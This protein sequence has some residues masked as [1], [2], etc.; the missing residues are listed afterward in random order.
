[1]SDATKSPST[2]QPIKPARPNAADKYIT[3]QGPVYLSG[4]QAYIRVT[5]EQQ[6][7]DREAGLKTGGF[8]S[9]YRGS[10][11]GHFDQDVA[12]VRPAMDER[13]I[14]FNP[15]V[16][17]AMAA[18]SV[19]GSQQIDFF[20]AS[21]YDGVFGMWYGKGPGVDQA[22]DALHHANLWGT[23][24]H[25][26]VVMA[27][28]DDPMSRSSSIQQQSEYVLSGL[29]I[30]TMACS[31]VQ[32]I[33]DYGLIAY[34]ISRYAGVWVAVKS[35]SDI[36]E[37]TNLIDIDPARTVTTLPQNHVIPDCGV[38]TRWPDQSVD[39]D[40]RMLKARLPAVKAFVKTNQ[41][42]RVT[43]D[44]P[45]RKVGIITA[46]KS[47][48]DTLEALNDLGISEQQRE[49]IGLSV[50][51]IAVTWPLEESLIQ[52][53]AESV[54][55]LLVIEESRPFLETQI[56]DILYHLP[57]A[58]R[59][60][61]LGKQDREGVTQFPSNGELTPALI[62]RVLVDWLSPCYQNPDM[63][64][65][66]DVLDR[67]DQQ[68]AI[69]RD[70]VDRTPYFCS[71]CPHNTS[72]KQPDGTV[73]LIGIGCHYLARLM[74]RGGVSY[75]QM[76]GEGATWAGAAPFVDHKHA[77][78]NL[79]DGTYYHS[80][81]NAIR[82]AI[83]AGVNITYKILYNDAVA[84]TGGQPH[85]G[86]V[87]VQSITHQLNAEGA[88][89]V[90]VV[91]DNPDKFNTR[92]FAKGTNLY[93]RDQL[94]QVMT[95][96]EKVPGVTILI[97][98]QTCATELRR[99]RKRGKAED[100]AKRAYINYR[101][102]EGCGDCGLASNCLSVQPLETEV[103]R[104]RRIDQSG[105]NKDFSCVEGFCP[106]FVT[107][108]GGAMN[109]GQGVEIDET[110]FAELP[111]PAVA[112]LNGVYGALV[113]GIGGTGVVTI[114]SLLG[115]AAQSEGKAS[116]VLDLTGMAQKFGA[117]YCHLKIADNNDDL[118]STRLSVGKADLLVGAD[119]V[120]SASNEGLSRLR[121][122]HTHGVVNSHETVTGAFT[123]DGDFQI[124]V[125]QM[126]AA[127]ERFT[128]AG[129]TS[130]FDSI[131]L[132]ERLTGDT[133]GA[134]TMLL[135]FAC[136]MGWLPVK[137]AS[138]EA[139]IEKNGIAVA[140]NLR[141]FKIGRMMAWAPEQLEPL[142]EQ[143]LP[144][145]EWQ[146]LSQDVDQI[147]QRRSKDLVSYQNQAYAARYLEQINK[148]KSAETALGNHSKTLTEAVA[149]NLYKLMAYKDEYEV[150]R[151]Y[152]DGA[153]LARINRQFSGNFRLKFHMAPPLLSRK[154]PLTGQPKKREFG[155]WMYSGLKLVAG[156][157]G[158][159]GT[160]F[161]PFGYTEE[162]REERALITEYEQL[163]NV[164]IAG[165]TNENLALAVEIAN[166]P[167]LIKG[168]GH[169]KARNLNGARERLSILTER[170]IHP[171]KHIAAVQIQDPVS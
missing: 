80:G 76:G 21:E 23:H 162:R 44:C 81:S 35:V 40:E 41:L 126:R 22:A 90:V 104:K 108:E 92:E 43:L 122:G 121:E 82:Q 93:H 161:D 55:E 105:C 66:I 85:D 30:P 114:S 37:A 107:I 58:Q 94:E 117:V 153:W 15:G 83:A 19:W 138:L 98:E 167:E 132:S 102:C 69:P 144:T 123:R 86:P 146:I 128:G 97:Y 148:I 49:Q 79:G 26:G 106:S 147:I 164:L 53:F 109:K 33:Y 87:S 116:Q 91:S 14:H 142:L 12:K 9:G 119:I 165:L 150:A 120:T 113:C 89:K 158:L 72:T 168:F 99:R 88:A 10:P 115:D 154:D 155:P 28:G 77:F 127:I 34:Q 149:R 140:Y 61:V 100:P 152:T 18:T 46:G 67:T 32:D 73:Q 169:V 130:F 111:E 143:A 156:F 54:D 133:I 68:L 171:D 96:L 50:F 71:G 24:K 5:F 38:H 84:M 59:P 31:S 125:K 131:S 17:E 159:R 101:L 136:Q 166:I 139:A 2:K 8:I 129:N 16:N 160:R 103:G 64:Q 60:L 163:L 65:W 63:Q 20:G 4:N 141:A 110:T 3:D 6:R 118:N 78:I 1:M 45:Q 51:K 25:G 70:N 75:T 74:D 11:F 157:K 39:Q 62:S 151:L 36:A 42:N 124:P 170:Y 47:Y 112:P 56:K 95:E 134:N 48:L 13:N 145:P 135:G 7:R 29:C 57:Q 52:E 27:V 137:L